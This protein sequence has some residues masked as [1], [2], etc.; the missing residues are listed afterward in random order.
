MQDVQL[1]G[2]LLDVGLQASWFF[3]NF[4]VNVAVHNA[5]SVKQLFKDSYGIIG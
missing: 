3:Y 5:D 4:A 1:V 2:L